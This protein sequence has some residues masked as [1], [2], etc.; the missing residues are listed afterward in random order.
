MTKGLSMFKPSIHWLYI[1]IPVCVFLNK[2]DGM[3]PAL[4]FFMTALA[5]I[6]VAHL[7]VEATEHLAKHTGEAVGGLLNATF[8]NA[9]ELI[10]AIVALRAGH[11]EMVS[12]SI[13]GAILANL[14]MAQGASFLL[15]GIRCGDQEFNTNAIRNY[16]TMMLIAVISM[17]IPSAFGRALSG[18]GNEAAISH[19]NI[20]ISIL[21]LC[22]YVLFLFFSLRTHKDLF[23]AKSV[24]VDSDHGHA[25]SI[26]R[27]VITLL[28]AS[29][30]AA[31]LSE[32]LV[33]SAE[34]AGEIMGMSEAFIGLIC[35]A[36]VGGA[37]ESI[38]AITM[39]TKGRMDLSIGISMG[40][41]IQIALFVAPVLVLL[42]Y[43]IAPQPFHLDFNARL[44]G[45]LLLSVIL[46]VLV[47]GDGRSNWFKGVQ[48]LVLYF[49]LA[50]TLYLIPN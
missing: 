5:I 25:W 14:L 23:K 12:A 6:P 8:G 33:G 28:G 19:L 50:A 45:F 49:M 37:A 27:A 32:I 2:Q 35:V 13:I 43:F 9:P 42:S 16:G 30:L 29:A 48:L 44:L 38:S 11:F 17:A 31:F 26:Q 3:S 47:S 34:G 21:L 22:T 36:V 39:G 18:S 1:L 24:S 10:I 40:S 7:I 20:T 46:G 15:G 41:S 4:I